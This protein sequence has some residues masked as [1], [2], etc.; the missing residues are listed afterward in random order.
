M[1]E[2]GAARA[3]WLQM[4]VTLFMFVTSARRAPVESRE[5]MLP[6]LSPAMTLEEVLKA[7]VVENRETI[8]VSWVVVIAAYADSMTVVIEDAAPA[9]R[10]MQRGLGDR[11]LAKIGPMR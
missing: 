7:P 9:P 2:T 1:D 3:V 8:V 6:A 11:E 4:A 5:E 10:P